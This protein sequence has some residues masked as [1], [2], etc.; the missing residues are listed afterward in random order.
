MK[1]WLTI[2]Q[3]D[4]GVLAAF[5]AADVICIA[6]VNL[7]FFRL[8]APQIVVDLT[9]GLVDWTLMGSAIILAVVVGGVIFGLGRMRPAEVGLIA[10]RLPAAIGVTVGL[11]V[12]TQAVLIIGAWATLGAVPVNPQWA[13]RGATAMI[14]ALLAQL[15]G[16]ALAEEIS[17]RGFLLPQTWLKLRGG[18]LY[19]VRW[20]LLLAV[21]ISQTFFAFSHIPNRIFNGMT[22]EEMAFDFVK[23]T[24]VGAY[25]AFLYLRTD[26]LFFA[27]GVHALANRPT[28]IVHSDLAS[29][30]IMVMALGLAFFW[31]RR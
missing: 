25:F 19:H 9:R 23:L 17:Y 20:R 22:P 18:V 21:L 31:R 29:P 2:K 3:V 1:S 11:W 15:F 28:S 14:G 13:T 7:Y 30:L 26:N 10:N 5:G 16:N 8:D 4:W 12:A 24:V 27:V 6:F